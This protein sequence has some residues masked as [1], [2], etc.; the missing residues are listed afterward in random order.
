MLQNGRFGRRLTALR[1]TEKLM[2]GQASSSTDLKIMVSAA[3][4]TLALLIPLHNV[5]AQ[6]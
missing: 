3:V 6:A 4:Y 1:N 5:G 2:K